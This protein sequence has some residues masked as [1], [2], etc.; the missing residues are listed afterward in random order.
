[1]A[2]TTGMMRRWAKYCNKG[3]Q[4]AAKDAAQHAISARQRTAACGRRG[5]AKEG[6]EGAS[7]GAGTAQCGGCKEGSQPADCAVGRMHMRIDEVQTH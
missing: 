3:Q 4:R 7:S 6:Q 5:M 1:M 2:A